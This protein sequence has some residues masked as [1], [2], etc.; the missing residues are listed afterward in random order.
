MK[1]KLEHG[2]TILHTDLV[3]LLRNIDDYVG[4]RGWDKV[5]AH[6]LVLELAHS[7]TDEDADAVWAR[8]RD[9][10]V[11]LHTYL[12]RSEP[13]WWVA[14]YMT[15]TDDFEKTTSNGAEQENSRLKT[16]LIRSMML[17]DMLDAVSKV[18]LEVWNEEEAI[19]TSQINQGTMQPPASESASHCLLTCA[20]I[21]AT[22]GS[23]GR[24]WMPYVAAMV[25]G[26]FSRP[27]HVCTCVNC[28]CVMCTCVKRACGMCTCV[29]CI[30]VMCTCVNMCTCA[31]VLTCV[32]CVRA[33]EP[34]ATI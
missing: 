7:H 24:K 32:T 5:K 15:H 13:R 34:A 21:P 27:L 18:V 19:A 11:T 29:M 17:L 25:K 3:H 20:F 6:H 31:C 8:I 2:A 26:M 30:C 1:K 16:L 22:F 23:S 28:A 33:L 9:L 12:K 14:A 10:N 4:L